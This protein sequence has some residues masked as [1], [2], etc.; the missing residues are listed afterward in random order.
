MA[1][2]AAV[3]EL[4]EIY[5][6]VLRVDE[7]DVDDELPELGVQSIL[8]IQIAMAVQERLQVELPLETFLRARTLRAIADAVGQA[9]E[10]AAP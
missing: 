3:D 5:R 10:G 7:L 2:V 1:T 9:R 4:R 6:K 8:V